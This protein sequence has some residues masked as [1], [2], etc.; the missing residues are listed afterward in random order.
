MNSRLPGKK[1]T[2]IDDHLSINAKILEVLRSKMHTYIS[3]E[4]LSRELNMSRTAVWKHVNALRALG[5]RVEA[6]TS[7]GYKLISSPSLLLPLEIKN[8]LK[9]EFI[10]HQLYWE[11]ELSSTNTMALQLAEK[12][13]PEGTVVLSESQKQ[14]RGRIGANLGFASRNR[15]LSL[16]DPPSEFCPHEIAA[17]YFYVRDCRGGSAG[18]SPRH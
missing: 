14:G 17:D 16:V 9:T 3:G 11:Y 12:G 10:G 8:G 6:I 1:F 4:Q 5:Y 15:D 18:A 13:A 2:L 7:M